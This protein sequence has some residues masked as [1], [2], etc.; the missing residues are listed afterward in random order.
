V[1]ICCGVEGCSRV[2]L[3]LCFGWCYMVVLSCMCSC[4]CSDCWRKSV[5][6][7]RR[8]KEKNVNTLQGLRSQTQESGWYSL[9]SMCWLWLLM[10]I[11]LNTSCSHQLYTWHVFLSTWQP[12]GDQVVVWLYTVSH[13]EV[14]RHACPVHVVVVYTFDYVVWF[15]VSIFQRTT[16]L[17][18]DSFTKLCFELFTMNFYEVF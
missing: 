12:F 14:W 2:V 15:I 1:R 10:I 16:V 8:D 18:S 5:E 13:L 6:N 9:C 11:M 7:L 3:L 4:D 17:I